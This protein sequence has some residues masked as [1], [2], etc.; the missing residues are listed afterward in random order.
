[1]SNNSWKDV[2]S[3]KIIQQ[4]EVQPQVQ[5]P[6]QPQV[7]SSVQSQDQPVELYKV[8]LCK[9]FNNGGRC[10]KGDTC[11]FAHGESELRKFPGTTKTFVP[12]TMKN[13]VTT[14]TY[15]ENSQERIVGQS[16]IGTIKEAIANAKK[17]IREYM[18]NNNMKGDIKI[19][20]KISDT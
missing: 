14:A 20:I 13:F 2:K 5:S 4:E 19:D 6:V 15:S 18:D 1:M 9:Y 12:Y 10:N 3:K 7:Q 11:T 17:Y 8:T 16:D